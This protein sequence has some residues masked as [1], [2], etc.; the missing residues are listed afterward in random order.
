MLQLDNRTIEQVL[1]DALI[2]LTPDTHDKRFLDKVTMNQ[3]VD[4]TYRE[5]MLPRNSSSTNILVPHGLYIS[6]LNQVW[7]YPP[8]IEFSF[9]V[10]VDGHQPTIKITAIFGIPR[11]LTYKETRSS[12]GRRIT[13]EPSQNC[14]INVPENFTEIELSGKKYDMR[15]GT[16]I[17]RRSVSPQFYKVEEIIDLTKLVDGQI[18]FDEQID[19]N[20]IVLKRYDENTRNCQAINDGKHGSNDLSGQ[21][22]NANDS[23]PRFAAIRLVNKDISIRLTIEA[24]GG[25]GDAELVLNVRLQNTTQYGQP[26]PSEKMWRPLCLL[27]PSLLMKTDQLYPLIGPQ[28][29][30]E[31]R[32][33]ALS[34]REHSTTI[35][36]SYV[37]VNGVL[38][39]STVDGTIL[40]GTT[41]GVFDL[42]RD[43]PIK[44][45]KTIDEMIVTEQTLLH[46]FPSDIR[47]GLERNQPL[48][49]NVRIVLR[50]IKQGFG[51]SQLYLY[52]WK[53]IERRVCILLDS[54]TETVTI[55]KA[56]TG[57]GKTIVFMANAA[58]HYLTT[59]ERAALVFPTRI[60]N[61]DMFKRLTRFIHSL[62]VNDAEITGGIYIGSS[63][64]L[65]QAMAFPK[66]GK[67]MIQYGT[68]PECG[69]SGSVKA[70]QVG[71]RTIG[72]CNNCGHSLD[73]MFGVREV[74]DYL[75]SIVIA[76]PDKLF[77]DVTA[78]DHEDYYLR[79]MGGYFAQCSC[80]VCVPSMGK[81]EVQCRR[82][83]TSFKVERPQ[84]RPLSYFVFDE[85]H[86]LYGMTGTLLSIFLDSLRLALDKIRNL[87]SP[88]I[89]YGTIFTF[90]AGTATIANEIELLAAITRVEK[91]KIFT[92]PANS[93][94]E[95][96]FKL[97]RERV[98]YRTL[99]L[100][101]V[102]TS[103]RN[104][105]SKAIFYEYL[106]IHEN[107]QKRQEL[108]NGI[109]AL[110]G[111][112]SEYD[113]CLGYVFRKRDGY[114]LAR[115]INEFAYYQH[116]SLR[117][118]F[119]SG[120]SS[121]QVVAALFAKVQNEEMKVLIA[122]LV[123]SLGIDLKNLNNM[124]ALGVTKSMTEHVQT[125]GRTGRGLIPGHVTLHLLPS[126]PRDQFVYENFHDVFSDVAG[127]YDKYP[128]QPTNAFA[129]QIILPNIFKFL[130]ASMSY[131]NYV[132][133]APSLT[134]Y[135][136]GNQKKK[137]LL[138]LDLL[139]VLTHPSAPPALRQ[140]I[141]RDV[142]FRLDR[143]L[144]KFSEFRGPGH[145]ISVIFERD[146]EL[147]TSLRTRIGKD[148]SV[149]AL[150]SDIYR[151]MDESSKSQLS[152]FLPSADDIDLLD[153]GEDD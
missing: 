152:G 37:Q 93:D 74:G 14:Q 102:A 117:T 140:Q 54:S 5:N 42:L 139:K 53:A 110:G 78:A 59:G 87:E 71:L 121:S 45:G 28:Q 141:A 138:Y 137:S 12:N 65:Y 134:K 147:L 43:E 142:H 51:V 39:R 124:V 84:S 109:L 118:K 104:S 29:H 61:E 112:G 72:E 23:N 60:L 6:K 64:P 103:A 52:Q 148:I 91:D 50:S 85:V 67:L 62:R 66:A 135:F 48:L 94:Y 82:C 4:S 8:F 128:I 99:L 132:L 126:N 146:E 63:D 127:Y 36:P 27:C 119:L 136:A 143:Y 57:S 49:K 130:L 58:L 46:C 17:Y 31:S 68:C 98:R 77:H 55:V 40:V 115:T 105:V 11:F 144:Q 19:A 47:Q 129:A 38:T 131:R 100:L 114:N 83:G 151:L 25:L 123:M 20:E 153:E 113:F 120:D 80:G 88:T 9:P 76:T 26:R 32:L 149:I 107:Q 133:T 111:T 73:Y 15:D 34:E 90:E 95:Q 21:P 7:R 89:G 96:F 3:L 35:I 18:C 30:E 108:Q 69:Q 44:Y 116:L 101:P 125:A 145:Y 13:V 150:E 2:H 22:D 10:R 1:E 92:T 56:P 97:N 70:K 75:P 33:S 106:R 81:G 79:V 86:S 41:F 16:A 24:T 122:N